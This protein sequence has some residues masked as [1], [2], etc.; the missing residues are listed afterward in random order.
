MEGHREICIKVNAFVDEGIAPLVL[1]LSHFNRLATL[2]S[3]QGDPGGR[4]AFVY[5]RFGNWRKSGEFLFDQML[6]VLPPDLRSIV[7]LR[8]QAYDTDMALG[9]ITM[10][11]QAVPEVTWC[12]R[13][14]LA[15][16]RPGALMA[17]DTHGL[18][19]AKSITPASGH[20]GSVVGMP[21]ISK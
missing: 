15:P 1:A 2:E 16:I 21:I 17:R 11:P 19:V 13:E 8:L 9:S 3:C 14:L 7:S 20:R 12:V 10:E 5:F 6:A 4:D 18:A